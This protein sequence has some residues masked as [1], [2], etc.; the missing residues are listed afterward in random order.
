MNSP[1]TPT[2]RSDFDASRRA[3]DAEH[4]LAAL[5]SLLESIDNRGSTDPLSTK[6]TPS[7]HESQLALARLGMASS[8]FV[9]LRAK[10]RPTAE[11]CLRVALGAS[12]WAMA[13]NLPEATRD[14]I[15]VAALLH[16]VGKVG[17]PD[18]VLSKPGKL[19]GEELLLME[20]HRQL[21]CEI[22]SGCCASTNVLD[23]VQYS[24]GWYDGT[25]HGFDRQGEQLPLGARIIAIVDAFD[26]M[27]TDHVYRRAM[28]RER[29][30]AELFT[31]SGSQFDPQL[32]K[33]FCDLISQDKVQFT[34][35]VARRWLQQISVQASN[36]YWSLSDTVSSA[37]S[38]A[39]ATT[40]PFYERLL[41]SMH[42]GVMFV[43]DKLHVT[44]WNRGIE[45][46][47]GITAHSIIG[48]TWAPALIGL[49]DERGKLIAIEVCPI[50]HAMESGTQSFR[51]LSLLG[52]N[53]EPVSVDVQIAPVLHPDGVARGATVILHDASSQITL[54][55][56]VESLAERA[57]QDPLT[58]L[59]NR[60]EFDHH[61]AAFVKTH[62]EHGEP[63]SMIICD[64]D[65]FKK[66][67]D[68]HGHQA[69]DDALIRF[70]SV[71][72]AHARSGDLVAR[73]GGEEFVVLCADCD[74]ATATRR[75]EALRRAIA[76]HM[77]PS[78]G[79]KCITASFGVTEVQGGDTPETFLNRADRALLQAKDNGRNM[80]V[81]LG[82]G[83]AENEKHAASSNWLAWFRTSPA[84]E[85]LSR[86]LVTVV[87]MKVAA[88][89]LRGF[90]ADHHAEIVE[91][92][93]NHVTLKIDESQAALTKRWTDRPMPFVMELTFD[94]VSNGSGPRGAVFQQ[95][96]IIQVV[97][98]PRRQRDRR[99]RDVQ[100]RARQLL[101][102]LKSYLMAH[103]FQGDAPE[104]VPDELED[105][106]TQNSKKVLSHWLSE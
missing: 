96:T 15:E 81:Q 48:N 104:S 89:K 63:C 6:A 71:L 42:D 17:V 62:L 9:A 86:R 59:A 58:K 38:G 51:R 23:I 61:L 37:A 33:R 12:S 101:V 54:E 83:I 75:A 28:S 95:Q 92:R 34:E 5:S 22:I 3:K 73:Y 2:S 36:R 14:D 16:D 7:P 26:A 11:H 46:L 87:P 99:C 74:N 94:E 39:P 19:S 72:Q 78:L 66:I 53:K 84:D 25:K 27:T 69:G 97:V 70:A 21:G 47:T 57:T 85:L 98:R 43:D 93:D 1:L 4:R 29:A 50:A 49:K 90:V 77:Q 13:M 80:V 82:T 105:R 40:S 32:V 20:R 52:R 102:S 60:A 8:L 79:N 10:H 55:E 18:H 103:D 31:Y 41:D 64:I 91:I 88:E 45:R 35:T 67:N 68:V 100:E 106:R 56:R 30:V 76:E 44:A 24:P 65:H